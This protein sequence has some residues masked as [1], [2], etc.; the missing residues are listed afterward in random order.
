MV[1][2]AVAPVGSLKGN[3]SGSHTSYS[4]Y[5]VNLSV[6]TLIEPLEPMNVS[7]IHGTTDFDMSVPARWE[8][9]PSLQLRHRDW[10]I[11]RNCTREQLRM[12]FF[13]GYRYVGQSLLL[14]YL[15]LVCT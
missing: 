1:V 15:E 12:E 13:S 11:D 9:Q 10:M 14:L 8:A 5:S 6:G 2:N 4:A 3:E 7:P